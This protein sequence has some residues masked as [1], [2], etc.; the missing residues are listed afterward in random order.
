MKAHIHRWHRSALFLTTAG[1][2]ACGKLDS[3]LGEQPTL[4]GQIVGWNLTGYTLQATIPYTN[5]TSPALA[6]APIDA[7]GHFSITLPNR[8]TIIPYLN[9]PP[10]QQNCTVTV[11]AEP[12]DY[13]WGR[14]QLTA[15]NGDPNSS[16]GI[17]QGIDPLVIG[18]MS[19]QVSYVYFDRDRNYK[20]FTDCMYP[21]G[22]FPK[23]KYSG[24]LQDKA[25]W[26]THIG[27]AMLSGTVLIQDEHTGAIPATAKWYF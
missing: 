11:D 26:N 20:G 16:R 18:P 13:L 7:T 5:T 19:L 9:G 8:D 21:G 22:P 10:D 17:V 27:T 3:E 4:T 23:V 2:L 14:L 24:D 6:S 25:G 15:V 1:L 12:L